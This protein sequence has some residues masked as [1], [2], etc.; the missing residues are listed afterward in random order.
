MQQNS[1]LQ[2]LLGRGLSSLLVVGQKAILDS[3]W[4]GPLQ[5][6]SSEQPLKEQKQESEM[7]D[8]SHSVL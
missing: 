8:G 4:Y 6:D 1:V 7:K 2:V 5:L 3:L